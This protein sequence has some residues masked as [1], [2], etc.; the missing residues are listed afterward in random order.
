M[1]WDYVNDEGQPLLI[2]LF[3]MVHRKKE[4]IAF[5]ATAGFLGC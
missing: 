3:S 5:F 1:L 4:Q 2:S